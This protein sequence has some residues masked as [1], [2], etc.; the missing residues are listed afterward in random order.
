MEIDAT[1]YAIAVAEKSTKT[2]AGKKITHQG[3]G[4]LPLR[5]INQQLLLVEK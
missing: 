1:K 4:G 3:N 2:A 5:L